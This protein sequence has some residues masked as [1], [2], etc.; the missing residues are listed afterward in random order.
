MIPINGCY[1]YLT[2]QPQ[3]LVR[4]GIPSPEPSPPIV[5]YPDYYTVAPTCCGVFF[6]G[7][8]HF[9]QHHW[10]HGFHNGWRY[11]HR[12]NGEWSHRHPHRSH[13]R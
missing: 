9:N 4:I 10:N 11:P 6:G 1:G 8:W 3:P 7:A 13:D 5:V 2:S 12:H